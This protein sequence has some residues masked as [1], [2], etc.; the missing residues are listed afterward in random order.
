MEG[1]LRM[2]V[3]RKRRFALLFISKLNL[4]AFTFVTVG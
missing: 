4:A 2:L 3:R 1:F